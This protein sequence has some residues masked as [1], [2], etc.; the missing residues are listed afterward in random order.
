M[1]KKPETTI[2]LINLASFTEAFVESIPQL[3]LQISVVIRLGC[4]SKS[5]VLEI[6]VCVHRVL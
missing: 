6:L 4:V 2:W 5:K 1:R 3:V